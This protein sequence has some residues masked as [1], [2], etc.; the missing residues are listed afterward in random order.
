MTAE[1]NRRCQYC[2]HSGEPSCEGYSDK[3]A[4]VSLVIAVE[5]LRDDANRL[6]RDSQE[7]VV[8]SWT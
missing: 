8:V 6:D 7:G 2:Y 1:H 4:I 3:Q 5:H